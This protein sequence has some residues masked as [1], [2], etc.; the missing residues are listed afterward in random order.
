[1]GHSKR[2]KLIKPQTLKTEM[3]KSGAGL[4]EPG[5]H[6]GEYCEQF[7]GFAQQSL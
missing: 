3:L 5:D 7:F 2:Q 6:A 4:A 1:M